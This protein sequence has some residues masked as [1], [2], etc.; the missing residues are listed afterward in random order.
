MQIQTVHG[1]GSE[2]KLAFASLSGHVT[3]LQTVAL[4]PNSGNSG[5]VPRMAGGLQPEAFTPID[6]QSGQAK[7]MTTVIL[8]TRLPIRHPSPPVSLQPTPPALITPP[9]TVQSTPPTHPMVPPRPEALNPVALNRTVVSAEPPGFTALSTPVAHDHSHS[10][11]THWT[12]TPST[13]S[14]FPTTTPWASS[15]STS[16]SDSPSTTSQSATPA[17]DHSAV[18]VASQPPHAQSAL[19]LDVSKADFST[20]PQ[21]TAGPILQQ[22]RSPAE[23]SPS[24]KET[25]RVAGVKEMF[26]QQPSSSVQLAVNVP[27]PEPPTPKMDGLKEL[28]KE[29][30]MTSLAQALPGALPCPSPTSASTQ[31][32][33]DADVHLMDGIHI[34]IPE[35]GRMH[36]VSQTYTKIEKPLDDLVDGDKQVLEVRQVWEERLDDGEWQ[37]V[38]QEQSLMT[39]RADI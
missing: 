13:A 19:A 14:S 20:R 12:P 2:N 35:D 4:S 22:L 21:C 9:A 38:R 10:H 8:D 37:V 16:A 34:T 17:N 28:F 6:P 25:P 27:K 23:T 5:N 30:S 39:K 26:D 36:E 29:A 32:L 7:K 18:A 31:R 11:E 33:A 24:V 15:S 1:D 3:C